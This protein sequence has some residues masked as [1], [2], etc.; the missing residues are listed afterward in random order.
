MFQKNGKVG[1]GKNNAVG[2]EER[3]K[4]RI[5]R[6]LIKKFLLRHQNCLLAVSNGF[7]RRRK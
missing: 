5:H 1:H 6:S 3:N 4:K 7:H 2:Y